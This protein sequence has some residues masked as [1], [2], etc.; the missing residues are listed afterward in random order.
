VVENDG[1]RALGRD[2]SYQLLNLRRK[3][4]TKFLLFC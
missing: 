2:L 1:R 4:Y 3:A